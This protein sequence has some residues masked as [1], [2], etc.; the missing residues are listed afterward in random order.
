MMKE[1]FVWDNELKNET[2]QIKYKAKEKIADKMH[3]KQ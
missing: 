1:P 2:K 3:S